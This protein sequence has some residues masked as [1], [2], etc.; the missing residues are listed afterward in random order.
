MPVNLGSV[1]VADALRFCAE[2][3]SLAPAIALYREKK[4]WFCP[5]AAKR[6]AENWRAELKRARRIFI[7]GVKVNPSDAPHLGTAS[8]CERLAGL[9]RARRPRVLE[10]VQE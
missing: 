6:I 1:V 10:L 2:Q 8:V 9:R 7:I 4:V 5:T 3:D